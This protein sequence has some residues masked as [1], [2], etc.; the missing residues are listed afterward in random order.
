[1]IAVAEPSSPRVLAYAQPPRRNALPTPPQWV[2]AECGKSEQGRT[3]G[4][5]VEVPYGWRETTGGKLVCG[6]RCLRRS[7]LQI[8]RFDPEVL[9][10]VNALLFDAAKV[11]ALRMLDSLKAKAAELDASEVSHVRRDQRL[12]LRMGWYER[13]IEGLWDCCNKVETCAQQTRVLRCQDCGTAWEMPEL[14]EQAL[15]CAVCRD[16]ENNE[17]RQRLEEELEAAEQQARPHWRRRFLTVTVPHHGSLEERLRLAVGAR[18]TFARSVRDWLRT[19]GDE[20]HWWSALEC[21]KGDDG[22][23][24]PHW[25]TLAIG[26]FLPDVLVA[27][28]W[29]RAVRARGG[30]V[31][32]RPLRAALDRLARMYVPDYR[33]EATAELVALAELPWSV[34]GEKGPRRR[35]GEAA[36]DY[37]IRRVR[38]ARGSDAR[39]RSLAKIFG[40]LGMAIPVLPDELYDSATLPHLVIDLRADDGRPIRELI[41]YT[42][43]SIDMPA[44]LIARFVAALK[45]LGCRTFQSSM[46]NGVSRAGDGCPAVHGGQR[47]GSKRLKI[48]RPNTPNHEKL[49]RLARYLAGTPPDWLAQRVEN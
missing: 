6:K 1:M 17:R 16:I 39:P 36:L 10:D 49:A 47:C 31:E 29:A 41:K 9:A 37:V 19:L 2:C 25:H 21:T 26:P 43:K 11:K 7:W 45:V 18:P 23:G 3:T 14:C 5:G 33:T 30:S 46:G 35:R 44:R 34:R 38:W 13:R 22:E 27:A 42:I 15:L 12:L 32:R 40:A 48:E 4:G 28:W 8:K 20:W 24:H